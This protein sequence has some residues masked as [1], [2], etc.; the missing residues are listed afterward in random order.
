MKPLDVPINSMFSALS[1]MRLKFFS[2][3]DDG[4]PNFRS[5]GN[6]LTQD[7]EM[8]EYGTLAFGFPTAIAE[9]GGRGEIKYQQSEKHKT[10][11]TS[12]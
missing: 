3:K 1:S 7:G 2:L 9:S 6:P 8:E 12:N 4:T 5:A 11:R 10:H